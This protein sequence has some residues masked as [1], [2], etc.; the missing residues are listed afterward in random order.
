MFCLGLESVDLTPTSETKLP[1][2]SVSKQHSM[3]F[4]KQYRYI[5]LSTW[6]TTYRYPILGKQTVCT[7]NGNFPRWILNSTFLWI[8][9]TEFRYS[10]LI[11]IR[12]FS[13]TYHCCYCYSQQTMTKHQQAASPSLHGRITARAQDICLS[14]TAVVDI[15]KDMILD[16]RKCCG[17]E[18]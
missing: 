13:K 4:F 7:S 16:W 6:S 18:N 15:V 5:D 14:P 17:S 3:D 12:K 1:S 11:H 9:G 10:V 8:I 2:S